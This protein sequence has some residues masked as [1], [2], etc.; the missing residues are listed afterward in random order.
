MNTDPHGSDAPNLSTMF[1]LCE[2]V[3]ICVQLSLCVLWA[4]V[5]KNP[6]S[7]TKDLLFLGSSMS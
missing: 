1:D 2:S 3:F 4:S 7:L 5:V 6:F